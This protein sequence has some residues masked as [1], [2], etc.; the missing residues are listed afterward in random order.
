[1]YYD[2]KCILISALLY[3]I[4]ILSNW[5]S[6]CHTHTICLSPLHHTLISNLKWRGLPSRLSILSSQLG[7]PPQPIGTRQGEDAPVCRRWCCLRKRKSGTNESGKEWLRRRVQQKV[8]KMSFTVGFVV[9]LCGGLSVDEGRRRNAYR[10]RCLT[11]RAGVLMRGTKSLDQQYPSSL[12]RP[13]SSL[14]SGHVARKYS[15]SY[16]SPS[17]FVLFGSSGFDKA[18]DSGKNTLHVADGDVNLYRNIGIMAHIDAGKTTTSERILF[19][20]GVSKSIGEVHDG[21]AVMDWMD[22]ER[23]RGITITSAATTCY[24][25]PYCGL[26][27]PPDP[28]PENWVEHR[29]NLID[30]PGHVDFTVEVERS[31]RVLDGAVAVFDGVAG[32]EAQTETVWRQAHRYGIPRLCFINKM[33]RSGADYNRCFEEIRDKLGSRP[34]A[35]QMPMGSGSS[36]EGIVDLIEMVSLYW[37]DRSKGMKYKRRDIPEEYRE[38]A[39][40]YRSHLLEAAAE[41][42]EVLM[43]RYI[44]TGSLTPSEIRRGLSIG[45]K[46]MTIVPVLCGSSLKNR[47][48]QPLLD[49]IIFY[50]PSPSD[51]PPI[52]GYHVKSRKDQRKLAAMK[53][54]LESAAEKKRIK[55]ARGKA[56]DKTKVE[57]DNTVDSNEEE[58][59]EGEQEDDA[60]RPV[61]RASCDEPFAGLVFKIASD[62]HVGT[63]SFVRVY[64]GRVR[65]G[66][67][68]LNPRTMKNDRVQRLLLMH[69]N[70]RTDVQTLRAGEIGAVVGVSK[71]LTGDT[72]CTEEDPILLEEMEFPEPV[73]SKA[74]EASSSSDID[75]MTSTLNKLMH[76]D[77]S[78]H[79]HRDQ[80][81]GQTIISG[82]GELHLEII[83]DR[84]LREG[85]VSVK[86]GPPQVA[87]RETFT[88]ESQAQGR[89]VRQSGGRGQYGDVVLLAEPLPLGS[90]I[91]FGTDIYGGCIPKEFFSA[92]EEG[93]RAQCQKGIVAN[94]PVVN[95]KFTAIDGSHHEVDSSEMAFKIAAEMAVREVAKQAKPIILEPIMKVTVS[96]ATEYMGH[97]IGDLCGRRGRLETSRLLPGSTSEVI[98]DVP[99]ATLCGYTTVLR[100]LTQGRATFSMKMDEYKEMP[101][102]LGLGVIKDRTGKTDEQIRLYSVQLRRPRTAEQVASDKMKR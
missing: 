25:M 12:A 62:V 49:A 54:V 83:I 58:M 63:L 85:K 66:D 76:E 73:I 18:L 36:F 92:I 69:S 30:T 70:S 34:V 1:M 81:A 47:G 31:L 15:C 37:D 4:A 3:C 95:V 100:S 39:T 86:S 87:F 22:Q 11:E 46:D 80:E 24:W 2:Y 21:S 35:I 75:K 67:R 52:K 29:I 43:D 48:V 57:E 44:E 33:D 8:E 98:A 79:V 40:R 16:S 45:T 27:N 78:L 97:V 60:G 74:I 68:V 28:I 53:E 91:Q 77:P 55:E 14:L 5:I 50:L 71:Q 82:M 64:S 20:T 6:C 38:E 17:L 61:R 59:M 23:E 101:Y 7:H 56:A 26:I 90:G 10:P 19:Y 96:V 9:S 99:L 93:I 41:N 51:R 32:V 72:L 42:D 94:C 102:G 13:L 88:K 84:L 89:Y 65:C